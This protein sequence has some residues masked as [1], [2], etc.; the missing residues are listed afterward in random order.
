MI[1]TFCCTL[2][3]FSFLQKPAFF[4]ER[5]LAEPLYFFHNMTSHQTVSKPLIKPKGTYKI[6]LVGDSLTEFLGNNEL[7]KDDLK[8]YYPDKTFKVDNYGFGSTNILS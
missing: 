4:L 3:M 6:V 2:L 7:L 5:T 8:N 1:A